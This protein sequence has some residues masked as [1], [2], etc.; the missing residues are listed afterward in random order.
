DWAERFRKAGTSIG[1]P[2]GGSFQ[3]RADTSDS[4]QSGIRAILN[5]PEITSRLSEEHLQ[6]LTHA[7]NSYGHQPDTSQ[8]TGPDTHTGDPVSGEERAAHL[9]GFAQEWRRWEKS[10]AGEEDSEHTVL[11]P[12]ERALA[13]AFQLLGHSPEPG[14]TTRLENTAG[15][16]TSLSRL[17]QDALI[18]ADH[19]LQHPADLPGAMTLG[20]RLLTDAPYRHDTR[21]PGGARPEDSGG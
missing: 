7:L 21:L 16:L 9:D 20:L 3:F 4:T 1:D 8:T 5:N 10:P 6:T 15:D 11:G 14:F 12:P 2:F 13:T 19:L 17:E 18:V